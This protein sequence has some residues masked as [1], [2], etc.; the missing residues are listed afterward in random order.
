MKAI[1]GSLKTLLS[2]SQARFS[3]SCV[4]RR[5]GQLV[6]AVSLVMLAASLWAAG[7]GGR[8]SGTIQDVTGA[9]IVDARVT[10]TNSE[11]G[12]I[13][14]GRRRTSPARTPSPTYRGPL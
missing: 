11:T 2:A 7:E 4:L 13:R 1:Q 8:I 6:V 3:H 12:A 14:I 10:V 5:L 9:V